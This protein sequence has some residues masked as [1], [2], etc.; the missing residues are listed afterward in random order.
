VLTYTIGIQESLNKIFAGVLVGGIRKDNPI[1][2]EKISLS[3]VLYARFV[4]NFNSNI[5]QDS[6]A[7]FYDILVN[8]KAR[9]FSINQLEDIISNNRDLVLNSPYVD[10]SKFSAVQDGRQ[11]TDDEKIEAITR[12][13]EDLLIELSNEFV[14]EEEFNSSCVI[15]TDWFKNQYMFQTSQNMTRIMSEQGYED[16]RPG[17]RTRLYRGIEDAQKYYNERMKVIRE[18]SDENRIKATIINVDWLEKE[19]E[20]EN[21]PDEEAL[22][23][24]GIPSVDKMIGSL[25]RGNMFEVIGPPKGGKTRMLNYLVQRALAQGL[26]VAIWPLEGTKEEWMANQ[27][28][29]Y[30][31]RVSGIA[32]DSRDI[33]EKRYLNDATKKLHV[34]AAKIAL[35]TDEKMGRM[36]F[37]EGICY[38]EDM[39]DV[40]KAHYDNENP[41]DVLVMDS[42]INVLSKNGKGK[43]E[44]ISEAY[45]ML[46]AYVANGMR[47]P[48]LLLASAQLKQAVVDALRKN[49]GDTMEITSGGES[50]ETIRTPD[51]VVGLFSTKEEQAANIAHLYNVASRHS[52]AFDDMTI[53]TELQCCYFY[54]E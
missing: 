8:L 12:D 16:K 30:I 15:F 35:A 51:I 3:N 28:A 11:S 33:L 24:F 42:P 40:L 38:Y 26:N 48:A 17:G 1:L 21:K 45:M 6:Y 20:N 50:A 41:Y 36:S 13:L 47:R 23:T 19:N 34:T 46:K 4:A 53:R 52:A 32:F 25:R 54:E 2:K 5:F 44:R 18:L 14:T 39:I 10:L 29:A 7:I 43:V 27:E 22:I 9:V 49:P 31:K 37:I